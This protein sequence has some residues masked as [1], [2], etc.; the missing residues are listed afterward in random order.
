MIAYLLQQPG[1]QVKSCLGKI[2]KDA[3]TSTKTSL[4]EG[5]PMKLEKS[6][7]MKT[8][9]SQYKTC[10]APLSKHQAL[11]ASRSPPLSCPSMNKGQLP[12]LKGFDWAMSSDIRRS[13]NTQLEMAI[14]DVFH[15]ENIDDQVVEPTRFK[16]MLKQAWLVGGQV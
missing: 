7:F 4:I 1:M 6:E 9:L 5:I 12:I 3:K 11:V 15:C 10:K 13:N 16:Y 8:Q 14:A 2:D